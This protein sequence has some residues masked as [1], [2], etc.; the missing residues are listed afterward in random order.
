MKP[1]RHNYGRH[2]QIM[3]FII[4]DWTNYQSWTFFN[5]LLNYLFLYWI[6]NCF[7]IFKTV[8]WGTIYPSIMLFI[9]MIIWQIMK[10]PDQE[11]RPLHSSRTGGKIDFSWQQAQL[12]ILH[13]IHI[14]HFSVY[15]RITSSLP[16]FILNIICKITFYLLITTI[17]YL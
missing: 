5:K 7:I 1:T 17:F 11:A 14:T 9:N 10:L 2:E 3:C 16:N 12:Q 13:N 8:M 4:N 6:T 15:C